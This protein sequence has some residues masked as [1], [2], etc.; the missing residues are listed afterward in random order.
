[1]FPITSIVQQGA[2]NKQNDQ[3]P[4]S[5]LKMQNGNFVNS[6]HMQRGRSPL[7]NYGFMPTGSI[8]LNSSQF[9]Y[10][11]HFPSFLDRGHKDLIEEDVGN[12]II[13]EDMFAS[14]MVNKDIL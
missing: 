11:L 12:K 3:V 5:D 7:I 10:E 1:M 14:L 13:M 8:P 6:H 2:V 9:P 4:Q